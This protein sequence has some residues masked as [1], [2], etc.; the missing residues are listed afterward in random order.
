MSGSVPVIEPRLQIEYIW[1]RKKGLRAYLWLSACIPCPLTP[2][3]Q[4]SICFSW[5]AS[6]TLLW[7]PILTPQ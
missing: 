4:S 7:Y 5:Y 6:R 3:Y 2:R 1:K